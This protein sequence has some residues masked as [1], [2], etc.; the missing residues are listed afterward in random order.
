MQI[1]RGLRGFIVISAE[2][3][4]SVLRF[5][6]DQQ[7]TDCVDI[8]V[9]F[10]SIY[11][12]SLKDAPHC[13]TQATLRRVP[14]NTFSVLLEVRILWKNVAL[15]PPADAPRPLPDR[16]NGHIHTRSRN[17]RITGIF[18]MFAPGAS[19]DHIGDE[20][21][22]GTWNPRDFYDNVH[23][24]EKSYDLPSSCGL[25]LIPSRLFP[26]QRRS[27]RWLLAREGI[28]VS[29]DG[30]LRQGQLDNQELALLESFEEVKDA[31][32]RTC[33]VS[34][35]FRVIISDISA[36]SR[37]ELRGGILAEE[38]GLGKTLELLS[39][40][41]L[42]RRPSLSGT[43]SNQSGA[44]LIDSGA[45]LIITP[46]AILEQWKQEAQIHT[47][48]LRCV[49]YEGLHHSKFSD[50]E[51]VR[52]LTAADVVVTTYNVL[53]REVHF[54]EDPPAR[55]MRHARKFERRKSPLVKINWWRVCIDEA[56]MIETGV[57]NAARVARI[58]PR[59]NAWAVSGTPLRK[60]MTDIYGLL[61]FLGYEPFTQSA[62][63]W[64]RLYANFKPFFKTTVGRLALRH[65]KAHI[66][67]E[68]RLPHQKRV[69]ITVPFTAVEEQNYDQLFQQMCDECELDETG[70]PT[71]NTWDPNSP[72]TIAKM[73]SWLSRL[74]QACLRPEVGGVKRTLGGGG[75]LRSVSEVLETMIDQNDAQIRAEERALLLS[76]IRRGQLLENALRP[77][78]SLK[79]WQDALARCEPMVKESRAQYETQLALS[80]QS[81]SRLSTVDVDE[82]LDDEDE[83]EKDLTSKLGQCRQR[84]RAALE[85]QHMCKFFIASAYYQIKTDEYLTKPDTEEYR[86]LEKLEE[87]NYEEAKVIRRE[88]LAETNRKVSR[89]ID[90]IRKKVDEKGLTKIP[91][92]V[93]DIDDGG[94]E[95]RRFLDRIEEFCDAMNEHAK[96]FTEWRNHMSKLMLQSLIDEEDG[97]E[98][99][100]DEYES[101]TKQ[102][103]E[104]YVYMEA[105]R[106]MF[107]DRHDAITGQTNILIAHEIKQGLDMAK[108][109]QGPSP[110][111]YIS[112]MN[113]CMSLKI[114]NEL[115]SLRQIL[116]ELRS[117]AVSLE[118]QEIRGSSRAR[119]E[120]VIV[121]K[122][123]HEVSQLLSAQSKASSALE[124]EVELFR[125]VMNKRLEY[126]RQLQQISDTVAPYDEESKG[127]PLDTA[128]F[129][130]KQGAEGRIESKISTLKAKHR[131]LIH[132]RDESG[133]DSSARI[134]IICQ[135]PFEIGK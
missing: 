23:V 29:S 91:L 54:A 42:H 84:L 64:T 44:G 112:L 85:I 65:T 122:I 75:P 105:L 1:A 8:A 47:P 13:C 53:R 120:L 5:P 108:Q 101:S 60:D 26:F 56:Q 6:L 17:T 4:R 88:M 118:G 24:P 77:K 106:V 45:T 25:D 113:K 27:V 16:R 83:G 14:G 59:V 103:D 95:S 79:T 94:I 39:L 36:W 9:T 11:R 132:L 129:E 43:A 126:Y 107:A 18:D 87:D 32:G 66:K 3:C 7:R 34:H 50:D 46:Q 78:E 2:D 86:A 70:A 35:L 10:P 97:A 93:I 80:K 102:Q 109:E 133:A 72:R 68:L 116:T 49:E 71:T 130:L 58:I 134:C 98:L 125:D 52:Q 55:A 127:K 119:M 69:V 99:Q 131:Y 90:R 89:Y 121:N 15:L 31:D 100:G 135:C 124:R 81:D 30:R 20:T 74:R 33:Y 12:P 22:R 62:A 38:M 123:I 41:S 128:L 76:Q 21:W 96:Q 19:T 37:L 117:L 110:K 104:M 67:E 111:L 115:G 40:V 28:E 73:R 57:S 61:L 63:L 82:G 51:L 114:P 92:M 48:H